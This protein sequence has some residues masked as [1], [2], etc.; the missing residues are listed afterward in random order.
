MERKWFSETKTKRWCGIYKWKLRDC[1]PLMVCDIICFQTAGNSRRLNLSVYFFICLL[2]HLS[3]GIRQ[4]SQIKNWSSQTK[5]FSV[6]ILIRWHS[7]IYR[8]G[9]LSNPAPECKTFLLW[10]SCLDFYKPSDWF[11]NIS[12]L[13]L[14][15]YRQP[16][17]YTNN[18]HRKILH[19]CR[20]YFLL[21]QHNFRLQTFWRNFTLSSA[22]WV[23]SSA[24]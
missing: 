23:S 15:L 7:F 1:N 17:V 21:R 4:N 6:C 9:P 2:R 5:H 11:N 14:K 20:A 18:T 24:I 10:K 12:L 19:F 13:I 22:S 3:G 8:G 16:S